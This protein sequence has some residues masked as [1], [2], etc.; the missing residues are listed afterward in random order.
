MR[1]VVLLSPLAIAVFV[2]GHGFGHA[3]RTGRVL[4]A[5]LR[6]DSRVR[7]TVRTVAPGR[8]FP[9]DER[10]RI[11]PRRLDFGLVQPDA[12]TPDFDATLAA[13]DA[14]EECRH[15]RVSEEATRLRDEG[16]VAVLAD[17]PAVAFDAAREARIPAFAV[18]NFSWDWIYASYAP[19]RPAFATHASR[20]AES[21]AGATRLFRLPFHGDMG[22]FPVVEDVPLTVERSA[23]SR[24]EA[25]QRLGLPAGRPLALLSFGGI[26]FGSLD[27]GGLARQSE[28]L[29]LATDRV[30]DAPANVR[31]LD[32][33]RLDYTMLLRAADVVVTKPGWGITAASLVNGV[34]V[35]Y[36][37]RGAFPE[38]EVLVDAL[39]THGTAA[40][41]DPERMRR[42]DF[43]RELEALLARPVA[44]APVAADGE[45]VVARRLLEEI[46]A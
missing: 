8:L 1:H 37:S 19:L 28:V 7:L 46:G 15:E 41:V 25:R 44:D 18:G 2:T 17:I 23:C 34:R 40:F 22:A 11:D 39:E 29:F 33:A 26:G 6:A 21:Y 14:L 32:D 13:L 20:A 24:E 4:G 45:D 43:G 16:A 12:L 38:Y 27:A 30:P 42:A 36:T 5:L 3:V 35:L 9:H 31:W 10:L